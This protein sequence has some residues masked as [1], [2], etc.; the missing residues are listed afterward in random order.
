MTTAHPTTPADHL[1]EWF[2]AVLFS[3]RNHRMLTR[4]V[5]QLHQAGVDASYETLAKAKRGLVPLPGKYVLPLA[6]LFKLTEAETRQF[7]MAAVLAHAPADL[8]KRLMADGLVP[9]PPRLRG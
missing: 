1:T 5:A 6:A 7:A 2:N 8:A 3:G 9:E 4:I